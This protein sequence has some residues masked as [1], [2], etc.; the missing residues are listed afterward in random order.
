LKVNTPVSSLL[1]VCPSP[2]FSTA[3]FGMNERRSRRLGRTARRFG[4]ASASRQF[5]GSKESIRNEEHF[6]TANLA[7][8]LRLLAIHFQRKE[9]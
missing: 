7:S 8:A 1:Q 2:I 4:R 3:K 6:S 9:E 5:E